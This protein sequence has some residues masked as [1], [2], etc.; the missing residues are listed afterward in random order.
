MDKVV[1]MRIYLAVILLVVFISCKSD[2]QQTSHKNYEWE[3]IKSPSGNNS[4]QPF[5]FSSKDRL[6]MSW[7]EKL[8][9][10]LS[11]LKYAEFRDKEWSTPKK[12][13]EGEDWFVNWADFSSI[14]EINGD[15][16]THYLPKSSENTFAYDVFIKQ[17]DIRENRWR[18]AFKL[19]SDSTKTE[20]GFVTTIPYN[21]NSFF[22][23]WLDGRNTSGGH[24]HSGSGAMTVRAAEIT[25]DGIVKHEV[26]LDAKTCDCCQTS[27]AISQN[28]PIVVYRDR[29]D[30]EIRDIYISRFVD[31][32]WTLPKAIFNDNWEIKGC[33]VN[34]PKVSTF[35]NKMA[36]AWFTSPDN[37]PQVKVAFSNNNGKVFE[38]PLVIDDVNPIG[39]VDLEFIDE[40]NVLVSWITLVE[41]GAQL[42]VAKININRGKWSEH[43]VAPI[44]M[45]RSSGFPKIK[46]YDDEVF[47]AYNSV[48]NKEKRIVIKKISKTSLL[49]D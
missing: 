8:N 24:D 34:G 29:S 43:V 48:I 32:D 2:K 26:E 17:F 35:K 23:T 18:E 19:H 44:D 22:I 37:T 47:I 14:A 13:T 9:D 7:T 38:Q 45:S 46:I 4:A 40:D 25:I 39:R 36:I 16:I 28:G 30:N 21:K 5:L 20:H 12:I 33:P 42:R 41:T 15:I 11:S 1:V 27:A 49:N 10:S 3:T 31:G 6:L